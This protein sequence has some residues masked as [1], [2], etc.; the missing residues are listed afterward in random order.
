MIKHVL[1]QRLSGLQGIFSPVVAG[2]RHITKIKQG[3]VVGAAVTQVLCR[4]SR[5]T[6]RPNDKSQ[7][8]QERRDPGP[9][10]EYF[11]LVEHGD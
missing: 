4:G 5:W 9:P 2:T 1:P 11:F 8:R 6:F 3:Q 7:G 10:P